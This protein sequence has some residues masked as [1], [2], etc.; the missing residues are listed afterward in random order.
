MNAHALP[1]AGKYKLRVDDYLLLDGTGVFKGEKTE[2]IDGDI[3]VMSSEWVPHMRIKDEIAYRLRRLIEEERLGLFVGTS[4]SVALSD[5]DCP[6]PDVIVAEPFTSEMAV[7]R[8]AVRL[9]VE[10]S[11][12][13]FSFDLKEKAERYALAGIP[14]YW[15]VDVSGRLIHQ[16]WAPAEVTY[17][18]RREVPFEQSIIAATLDG[19]AVETTAL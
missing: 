4:G 12:S 10:V 13:T 2:L 11:A 3:I 6:Q 5:T 16:M 15:V 18:E 14:E 8:E 7:P 9:F 17:A 1:S 19:L